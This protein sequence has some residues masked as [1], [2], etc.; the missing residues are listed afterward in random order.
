[1][2]KL[3]WIK[4]EKVCLN[5]VH[6]RIFIKLKYFLFC[7]LAYIGTVLVLVLK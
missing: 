7:T 2:I 6:Y 1:M 4:K 5:A 3:S